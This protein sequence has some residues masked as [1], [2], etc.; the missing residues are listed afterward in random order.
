MG[1]N[2]VVNLPPSVSLFFDINIYYVAADATTF[3]F[4]IWKE[5]SCVWCHRHA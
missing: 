3:V 1:K 5:T 4:Q 2:S